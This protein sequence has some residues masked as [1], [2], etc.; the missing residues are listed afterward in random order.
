MPFLPTVAHEDPG[1]APEHLVPTVGRRASLVPPGAPG[2]VV[3]GAH[4]PLLPGGLP[5]HVEPGPGVSYAPGAGTGYL[6]D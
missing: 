4:G 1:W 3:G 5:Q 6:V 2:G